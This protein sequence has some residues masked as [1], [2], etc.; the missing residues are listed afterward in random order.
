MLY[1]RKGTP[2]IWCRFTLAGKEIYRSTGTSNRRDAE[3]FEQKVRS[4]VWRQVRLGEITFRWEQAVERWRL[5]RS[6]KRSFDR[7]S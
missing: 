4:D 2:H 7:S 1:R 6:S 5:E 3:R